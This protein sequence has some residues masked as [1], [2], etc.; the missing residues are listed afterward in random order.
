METIRLIQVDVSP[1][2]VAQ[3][4][5]LNFF[6]FFQ[7]HLVVARYGSRAVKKLLTFFGGVN[8]DDS[9]VQ[10]GGRRLAPIRR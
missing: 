5:G 2:L 7:T 9:P 10:T 3:E 4:N 1:A 6:N 8:R